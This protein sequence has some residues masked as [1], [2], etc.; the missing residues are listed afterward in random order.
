MRTC[1]TVL[2]TTFALTL[3]TSTSIGSELYKWVDSFGNVTYTDSPPPDSAQDSEEVALGDI[4][5]VDEKSDEEQKEITDQ[6]QQLDG[7]SAESE[8]EAQEETTGN[9]IQ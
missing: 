5:L 1:F 9:Q 4:E 3:F 2:I 6:L 7:G 8:P